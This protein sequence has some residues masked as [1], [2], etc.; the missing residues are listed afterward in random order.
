MHAILF[1]NVEKPH[2]FFRGKATIFIFTI[3]I[4]ILEL[5]L[6]KT[7]SIKKCSQEYIKFS[8]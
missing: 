6:I 2:L 1:E 5:F 7:L 4:V 3:I 8:T